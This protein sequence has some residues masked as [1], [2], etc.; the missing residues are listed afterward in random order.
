MQTVS[1]MFD[2]IR[3]S[4]DVLMG[5]IPF[6]TPSIAT[7]CIVKVDDHFDWQER[8]WLKPSSFICELPL[9]NAQQLDL[10]FFSK[11][12]RANQI[13][14][15]ELAQIPGGLTVF[16]RGVALIEKFAAELRQRASNI[17]F[18]EFDYPLLW[19]EVLLAPFNKIFSTAQRVLYAG[20]DPSSQTENARW[21]LNPSG[22]GIVFSHWKTLLKQGWQL[23]ISSFRRARYFRRSSSGK[24]SG[25]SVFNSVESADVFEFFSAAQ[26]AKVAHQRLKSLIEI[27]DATLTSWSIPILWSVRPPW[28]NNFQIFDWSIGGDVLLPMGRSI[29]LATGYS[30][31]RKISEQYDLRAPNTETHASLISGSISRRVVLAHLFFGMREDGSIV[32]D[33]QWSD[34]KVAI[35]RHSDS[36]I[37][38]EK[39]QE[40]RAALAAIGVTSMEIDN[41]D[42]EALAR[43]RT[44]L[45]LDSLP[46]IVQLP[47]TGTKCILSRSDS[48]LITEFDL[49]TNCCIPIHSV[50]QHMSAA[51]KQ[52][53]K[54]SIADRFVTTATE[55]EAID[56]LRAGMLVTMPC[57]PTKAC[58]TKIAS[59]KCGEMLGWTQAVTNHACGISGDPTSTFAVLARRL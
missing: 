52:R 26:D 55:A 4:G 10:G 2:N 47:R 40:F 33:P 27:I 20:A 44:R 8:D 18:L 41:L 49:E 58:V 7:S 56:A 28:S 29:Q 23:P 11:A 19:S 38:R 46:L 6:G 54:R 42:S 5:T 13:I 39:M 21:I 3:L 50:L 32:H 36:K 57:C 48:H 1:A 45:R 53:A 51:F 14:D 9:S 22:E 25:R 31:G 17:G 37:S 43:Q 12:L 15:N 34:T 24:H 30:L 35:L 59:W 16:P